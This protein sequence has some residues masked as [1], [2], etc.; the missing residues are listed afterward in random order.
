MDAPAIAVAAASHIASETLADA[1]AESKAAEAAEVPS[2][3]APV[4]PDHAPYRLS[5]RVPRSQDPEADIALLGQVYHALTGY[6][7]RDSFSLYISNGKGLVELDFPNSS[8]RYCVGLMQSIES[9][10]GSESIEVAAPLIVEPEK[11]WERK[12]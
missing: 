4:T 5:I 2:D 3:D 8:T 7:G 9:L 1:P 6:E 10:V 11:P 12:Q